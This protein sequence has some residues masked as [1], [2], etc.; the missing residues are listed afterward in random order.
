MLNSS[1]TKSHLQ[2][3]IVGMAKHKSNG[4][5]YIGSRCCNTK[6]TLLD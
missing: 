4:E 1:N 2:R 3:D 5:Y 6:T